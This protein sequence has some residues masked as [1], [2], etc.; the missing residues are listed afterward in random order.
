MDNTN[1]TPSY[2]EPESRL[3]APSFRL[4]IAPSTL[5]HTY[6]SKLP[7]TH[8]QGRIP[9]Y[10]KTARLFYFRLRPPEPARTGRYGE[11][12]TSHS[13]GPKWFCRYGWQIYFYDTSS[14]RWIMDYVD[15]INGWKK[16]LVCTDD[17]EIIATV[18]S[19]IGM[20]SRM[21]LPPMV[22]GL[23][24]KVTILSRSIPKA[25]MAFV[26]P[27]WTQ[28]NI[29]QSLEETLWY[30]RWTHSISSVYSSFRAS[31]RAKLPGRG[32]DQHKDVEFS[33]AFDVIE[34]DLPFLI[35]LPSLRALRGVLSFEHMK[36]GLRI[37]GEYVRI[38]LT[39]D[40]NHV[41]LP[42]TKPRR[43]H[44]SPKAN[45]NPYIVDRRYY[46]VE[47]SPNP[48]STFIMDVTHSTHR[49]L[50]L[51]CTLRAPSSSQLRRKPSKISSIRRIFESFICSWSMA[52][53]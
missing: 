5:V 21:L 20:V 13:Y 47:R 8:Q 24:T 43:S 37:Q 50:L 41:F 23:N 1:V 18:V 33:V 31:R 3:F 39:W 53:K 35:G 27:Y 51:M 4:K 11:R 25:S 52:R 10:S 2:Q 16:D 12:A 40:K 7:T 49:L 19:E 28:E 46:V 32:K 30:M 14:R 48:R 22:I 29:L 6:P 44:Y 34:G 38:A 42:I 15:G 36:L 26:V 45:L 17:Y 9:F